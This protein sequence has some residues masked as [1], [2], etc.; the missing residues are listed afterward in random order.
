MSAKMNITCGTGNL[1]VPLCASLLLLATMA[2]GESWP[3]GVQKIVADY[4]LRCDQ[5]QRDVV[6]YVD[7]DPQQPRPKATLTVDEKDIYEIEIA[8]DGTKAT[9]VYASFHCSNLGYAWCGSG[10]C[11]S[12]LI[13]NDAV[14]EWDAGGRPMSTRGGDGI[15]LVRSVGGYACYS[16]EG[17]AGYGASPCYEVAV[18]DQAKATFWSREGD[19]K[20]WQARS[21]Q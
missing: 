15:F 20:A 16:S 18:W 6:P 19:V 9:V 8:P 10:G 7:D 1:G 12:Y 11:T 21:E 17:V 13:V 4:E 2:H 5:G 3:S 14:F